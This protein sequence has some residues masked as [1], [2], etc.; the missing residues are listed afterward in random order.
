M[1]SRIN[2]HYQVEY[3]FREFKHEE[4]EENREML[5]KHRWREYQC[6]FLEIYSAMTF[7][8]SCLTINSRRR[9]TNYFRTQEDEDSSNSSSS[10]TQRYNTFRLRDII[11]FMEET[12]CLITVSFSCRS[13]NEQS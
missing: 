3:L 2:R 5:Y 4:H 8:E 6:A 10:K 11:N 12:R 1:T 7:R 9:R 13:I